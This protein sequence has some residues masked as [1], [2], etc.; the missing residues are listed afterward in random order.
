MN[1][2]KICKTKFHSYMH[3]FFKEGGSC[4]TPCTVG[5]KLSNQGK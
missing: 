5:S 2:Q 3:D 4:F 1:F